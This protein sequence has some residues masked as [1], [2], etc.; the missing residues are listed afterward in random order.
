M[1]FMVLPDVYT[2]FLCFPTCSYDSVNCLHDFPMSSYRLLWFCLMFARCP[3]IFLDVLMMSL[4]FFARCSCVCIRVLMIVLEFCAMFL[5]FPTCSYDFPWFVHGFLMF[6]YMLLWFPWS[7]RR[8]SDNFL[9]FFWLCLIVYQIS[10]YFPSCSYDFHW[11]PIGFL[12]LSYVFL[13][14]YWICMWCWFAF[15]SFVLRLLL[16]FACLF[17][18]C[19]CVCLFLFVWISCVVFVCLTWLCFPG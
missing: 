16:C 2:V 5:C 14:F 17:V 12:T 10:L 18:V 6:S 7:I 8:L 11:V 3:C 19:L 4:M 9:S 1:F 15:L 13:R